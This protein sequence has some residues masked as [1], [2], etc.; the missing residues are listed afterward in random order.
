MRRQPTFAG[1]GACAELRCTGPQRRRPTAASGTRRA[2]WKRGHRSLPALPPFEPPPDRLAPLRSSGSLGDPLDWIL[3]PLRIQGYA[4]IRLGP[5]GLELV[6]GVQVQSRKFFSCAQNY[7]NSFKF[8]PVPGGY[9]T[10]YPGTH[11][12][13]ELRRGLLRCPPE[14][15]GQAMSGFRILERLAI[16]V[17]RVVGRD[18]GIDL[19]TMPTEE[20]TTLRLI[21]YDEPEKNLG[22]SDAFVPPST[23]PAVGETVRIVGLEG[24]HS[25]LN[26]LRGSVIESDADGA[27]VSVSQAPKAVLGC[28]PGTANSHRVATANM[29]LIDPNTPGVYAAHTDS[30]LVT[31]APKSSVPGLE[32]K[33]LRSGEW[34]RIEERMRPDECL[35]FL[36]DPLD[37]ASAHRYRALMHRPAV[38]CRGGPIP[39]PEGE[40]LRISTPLFLYPRK[41]AILAPAGLP[42][43]LFDDMNGNI[44][45]CRDRFP[46]KLSSCYYSDMVYS[47]TDETKKKGNAEMKEK[48]EKACAVSANGGSNEL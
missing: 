8:W 6:N 33:D 14:L 1:D 28:R 31:I 45:N 7:K 17:V 5:E 48:E 15:A 40:E 19:A 35:V 18:I 30:S 43:L 3:D 2:G 32:V 38:P 12:I 39:L 25:A 16:D 34:F 9:L 44:G 11:E 26:G 21:R 41:E 13:F 20:S 29:R 24:A 10:P 27:L 36:G 47:D 46:W 22:A 42:R 23:P 37:Y 4:M